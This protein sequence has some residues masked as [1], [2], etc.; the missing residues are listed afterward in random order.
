MIKRINECAG[1]RE[2]GRDGEGGVGLIINWWAFNRIIRDQ[3]WNRHWINV[4]VAFREYE[5]HAK[6][7]PRLIRQNPID[8]RETIGIYDGSDMGVGS[9]TGSIELD[10]YTYIYTWKYAI[11]RGEGWEKRRKKRNS[12]D[13]S[14][15][16]RRVRKGR[17]KLTAIVYMSRHNN[18]HI[19][20]FIQ[21][22]W[23]S[24]RAYKTYFSSI[25]PEQRDSLQRF[26][27][28]HTKQFL[29]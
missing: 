6:N 5:M 26:V 3:R 16:S 24:I 23:T 25:G 11:Q 4:V 15:N 18:A 10:A 14:Y 8:E 2:R 1:K 22:K 28:A 9:G 19:N 7:W 29:V 17:D 20:R 13:W 27:R 12:W 21:Q